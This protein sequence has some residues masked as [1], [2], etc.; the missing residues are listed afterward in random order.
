MLLVPAAYI[1]PM[2]ICLLHQ[3]AEACENKLW[4]SDNVGGGQLKRC[5]FGTFSTKEATSGLLQENI[6]I[7][8]RTV[9]LHL[10]EKDT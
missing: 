1:S 3:F 9:S 7:I 5:L 4:R 10:C 8:G 2:C 6:M